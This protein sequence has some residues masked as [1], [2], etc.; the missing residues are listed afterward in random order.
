[1]ARLTPTQRQR[2][3]WACQT[4]HLMFLGPGPLGAGVGSRQLFGEGSE[5]WGLAGAELLPELAL[6][7]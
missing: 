1:M 2:L 6:H 5:A 3:P 7:K 4:C